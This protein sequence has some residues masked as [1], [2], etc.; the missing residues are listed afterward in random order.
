MHA[1][2]ASYHW[3]T[4]P[5]PVRTFKTTWKEL[6]AEITRLTLFYLFAPFMSPRTFISS[7]IKWALKYSLAFLFH[8]ALEAHKKSEWQVSKTQAY[9][10]GG[11]QQTVSLGNTVLLKGSWT[12]ATDGVSP[13]VWNVQSNQIYSGRKC[14]CSGPEVGRSSRKGERLLVMGFFQDHGNVIIQTVV[15]LHISECTKT[16]GLCAV[17]GWIQGIVSQLDY[18]WGKAT[19]L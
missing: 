2:Q 11:K 13:L 16:A 12:K 14:I 7:S 19:G 17:N 5:V 4:S 3:A 9:S 18:F 6:R 8:V 1:G 10:T 15:R